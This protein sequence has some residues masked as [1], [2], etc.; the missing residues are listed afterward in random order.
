MDYRLDSIDYPV[1]ITYEI[2]NNYTFNPGEIVTIKTDYEVL[3]GWE[4]Y[5]HFPQ[6]GVVYLDLEYG[7]GIN[8]N[9]DVCLGGCTNIPI[10]NINVPDDSIA[11]F[12]LNGQTG[13][14]AYPC[15]N[16][17]NFPPFSICQGDFLP[18]TF[19]NLFGIGL[20]GWITLPY[21]PTTDWFNTNDPCHQIL[22]PNGDSP[23]AYFD[24]IS[25]SF[26]LSLLVL[27]H[28]LKDLPYNSFCRC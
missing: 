17:N 20:S 12:Y 26:Y 3:P 19:N 5:S 24:W 8:L 28:R 23:Y 21:I 14:Y 7:F 1:Q 16:P 9:A 2:P 11:I 6:A 13:E 15:Y 25:Y 10:I 22:V 27:F 18:I 4:L